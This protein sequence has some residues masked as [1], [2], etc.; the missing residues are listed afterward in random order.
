MIPLHV[1]A[2]VLILLFMTCSFAT[3]EFLC[4]CLRPPYSSHDD[5]NCH[6]LH[7]NNTGLV[8]WNS[9]RG[10]DPSADVLFMSLLTISSFSICCP[11]CFCLCGY[12]DALTACWCLLLWSC[13]F[14]L[15]Y[16]VCWCWWTYKCLNFVLLV[17][18]HSFLSSC[19]PNSSRL[20]SSL[21]IIISINLLIFH[22][23][24]DTSLCDLILFNP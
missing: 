14:C 22:Y 21:L 6:S 3:C 11:H 5:N 23:Y 15:H 24:Q 18:L 7:D 4:P 17:V 12:S 13:S 1:L 20:S 9:P 2:P 10:Y 8:K 19:H 16:V